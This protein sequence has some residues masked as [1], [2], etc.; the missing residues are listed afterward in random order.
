MDNA[1]GSAIISPVGGARDSF[2]L[3]PAGV[4]RSTD[5][6]PAGLAGWRMDRDI[7]AKLIMLA[8]TRQND[9]VIDYEHQTLKTGENGMPAPAAGWFRNLEWR[10][11]DGLYA[12]G[13]KWTD[14][15]AKML[16]AQEYR[17]ISPTFAYN[18]KTG[19]V[20][21]IMSVALTNNPALDG[22]T[23]LAAATRLRNPRAANLSAE[24]E[25]ANDVLRRTFGAN[26]AT[27]AVAASVTQN[28]PH[29]PSRAGGG[30][31]GMSDYDI[32]QTNAKLRDIFGPN[33]AQIGPR[34]D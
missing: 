19:D 1:T 28:G 13:V 17:Y 23:D 5:G 15:A 7:A 31:G 25:Q 30:F 12:T 6:R 14:A 16:A 2:R 21:N 3:L 20:D 4:F 11:G 24:I 33:A 10:E 27:I 26:A 9:V 29:A 22:L 34:G 8:A 32:E 18:S